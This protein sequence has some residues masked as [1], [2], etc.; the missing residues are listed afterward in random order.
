[1]SALNQ[2]YDINYLQ[3]G[4][5]RLGG[6]ITQQVKHSPGQIDEIQYARINAGT[7]LIDLK[8]YPL[9]GVINRLVICI[10]PGQKQAWQWHQ[11]L[12]GLLGQ[13][14][15]GELKINQ[16]IFVSSTRV[17][18]GIPRGMVSVD[19]P[20]IARSERA[21]SLLMAENHIKLLSNSFHIV[22]CSGL[23][24]REYQK[25]SSILSRVAISKI[26]YSQG[27]D[28][29]RF[30]VN[31]E[32]VAKTVLERLSQTGQTSSYSLLTDGYCYFQGHKIAIGEANQ[33]ASRYRLLHPGCINLD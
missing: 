5:G 14:D 4:K 16:L 11:L 32:S 12:K 20:T 2:S 6:L 26:S 22:R 8:G 27:D 13:K 3:V 25:Y 31:V 17:Y 28:Q 18:D 30:G 21:K 1:M 7:G 19:T 15:R 23:Y 24:G 29:P 9:T 10:S 33:L